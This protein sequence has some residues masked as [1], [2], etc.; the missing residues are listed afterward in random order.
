MLRYLAIR[1]LAVIEELDLDFEPGL[2]VLTGETG[3]GKS[4]VVGAVGLLLGGRASPDLVRTGTETATVQAIFETADGGEILVRRE[5]TSQG[6]SRAF[7]DGALVTAAALRDTTAGLVD[8]HG[9][10][11]HQALLDPRAHLDLLD[12]FAGAGPLRSEV[13]E[14]FAVLRGARERL[15]T[16]RAEERSR[17]DRLDLLRFQL[18]E[19]TRVAARAGEDLELTAQRRVLSS[20]EKLRRL[21]EEGYGLLYEQDDSAMA[22]LGQAWKRVVELA[23][24]EARFQPFVE[25]RDGLMP[26]LDELARM[27]R[28]YGASIEASP[29]RLQQVEDRLAQLERV[30][31]KYGPTLDDV[32]ARQTELS[33][34][35]EEVESFD[36]RIGRLEAE[37]S[38]AESRFM[39][40]GRRLSAE[41]RLAADR[42]GPALARAL[43]ELAMAGARVEVR[44]ATPA[45]SAEQGSE[46]GLEEAEFYLSANAG[47]ELRPLAR[48]A[49]GGELSRAMLALKTLATTDRAG[50]T[51]VFDEVDSGIGGRVATVVGSR[52]RQL[53]RRFQVLCITHLPQIAA[54]AET[55]FDITK[56]VR[57]GRTTTAV[58]RLDPDGR[59]AELARMIGGAPDAPGA[60][61]SARELLAA[62]KGESENNAKGERG[63]AKAKV[64]VTRSS[65]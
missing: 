8:L 9:Q 29:A 28:D 27:L 64:A 59:I 6:R 24:I 35:M 50:K 44:L 3:A 36:E 18:D 40:L 46:R 39:Q 23:S 63:Q 26:Q 54:Q 61:A 56:G 11:E 49:S 62:A 52:L 14:A 12:E 33:R 51:L 58:R 15:A 17:L 34:E 13:A 4:I 45:A 16:L 31:R 10:H 53:G 55:H 22:S 47:E 43:S 30:K 48:I 38:D 42:F 20:A 65:R 41:R 7:I 37:A 1:N 25:M 57:G 32:L 60:I 21:C 2:N 19:L 5:V